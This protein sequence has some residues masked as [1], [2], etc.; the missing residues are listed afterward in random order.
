MPKHSLSLY[1]LLES[2]INYRYFIYL[3]SIKFKGSF[4]VGSRKT[5]RRLFSA[6]SS[7]NVIAVGG[8]HPPEGGL[9]N[10]AGIWGDRCINSR[11]NVTTKFGLG[12]SLREIKGS[13][14][15]QS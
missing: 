10:G 11:D 1:S 5:S 13:D 8:R 14:F 9:S 15:N 2:L 6:A 4:G 7:R 3:T 12:A